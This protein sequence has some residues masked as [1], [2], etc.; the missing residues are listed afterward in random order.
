MGNISDHAFLDVAIFLN[1]FFK[2]SISS[3]LLLLLQNNNCNGFS[4]LLLVLLDLTKQLFEPLGKGF[5]EVINFQDS[6]SFDFG[7]SQ[8][9]N[10][11]FMLAFFFPYLEENWS[12]VALPFLA[13]NSWLWMGLLQLSQWSC[14]LSIIGTAVY[15]R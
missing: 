2:E 6:L 4:L 15:S 12:Q 11:K 3:H 14:Q 1:Y 7:I 9:K 8:R 10:V 5:L 13:K